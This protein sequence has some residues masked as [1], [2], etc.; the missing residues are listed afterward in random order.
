MGYEQPGASKGPLKRESVRLQREHSR[1]KSQDSRQ[2]A[3]RFE[4]LG[5]DT[6]FRATFHA[7]VVCWC[8][9]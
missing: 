6:Q 4:N 8:C 5:C 1:V 3:A 7:G 9:Q 2:V